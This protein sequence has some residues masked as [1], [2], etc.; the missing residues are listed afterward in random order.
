MLNLSKKLKFRQIL[1]FVLSLM[2]IASTIL[3]ELCLQN[4]ID[5][6]HVDFAWFFGIFAAFFA[7][8]IFRF[9]RSYTKIRLDNDGS[10]EG[11]LLFTERALHQESHQDEGVL[12]YHL[13]EDIYKMMPWYTSGKLELI[14]EILNITMMIV[15]MISTN[16][17]LTLV[18]VLLLI[19]SSW[20]AND[21]SVK[22]A[23]AES[24]KQAAR[25]ILTGRITNTEKNINFIKQ[26]NKSQYFEKQFDELVNRVYILPLR[27]SILKKALFITQLVFSSEILPF[28]ILFFGVVFSFYKFATIGSVIVIVDMVLKISNSVQSIGEDVSQYHIAINIYKRIQPILEEDSC[29]KGHI[30]N[31]PADFQCFDMKIYWNNGLVDRSKKPSP[32]IFDV[33]FVRGEVVL[34][35]GE[36]GTGKTSLVKMIARIVPLQNVSGHILYNQQDITQFDK[37]EYNKRVLLVSQETVLFHGTILENIVMDS[38][39]KFDEIQEV[40]KVCALS[41]FIVEHGLDYMV[42]CGGSN[43]SSGERQRVGIARVLI[44]RPDILI[45]DE[46]TSALNQELAKKVSKGIIEFSR[47]YAITV[48][49]VCHGNEFDTY[50]SKIIKF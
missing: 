50:S 36:S 9:S 46:P 21:F 13:T 25:G 23:N 27:K 45:L 2:F 29:E 40:I 34:I 20:A 8:F 18:A 33:N 4:F 48:V 7:A 31:K 32:N 1:Y 42:A 28:L 43:L 10:L 49:V 44:R 26:L 14:L 38:K 37:K 5:L 47:K 3:G 11:Q 6:E 15:F 35:K 19:I 17:V 24:E 12:L 41:D 39:A 30:S 16:F 22:F